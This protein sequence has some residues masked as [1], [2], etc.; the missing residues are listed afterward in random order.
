MRRWAVEFL[1]KIWMLSIARAC[2][3]AGLSRRA[4]YRKDQAK[5]VDK[6]DD[7][8]IEALYEIGSQFNWWVS[9]LHSRHRISLSRIVAGLFL[10]FFVSNIISFLAAVFRLTR[11]LSTTVA[12]IYVI[13]C[14]K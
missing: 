3:A 7:P 2:L 10:A 1:T 4:W 5:E 14:Y 6:R 8:V 9:D 12:L 11:K 13:V